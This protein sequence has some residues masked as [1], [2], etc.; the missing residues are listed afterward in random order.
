MYVFGYDKSH[1]MVAHGGWVQQRGAAKAFHTAASAC[2]RIGLDAIN[3]VG[4][5]LACLP[6]DLDTSV[7]VRCLFG[8]NATA[9]AN[10]MDKV[11]ALVSFAAGQH[12]DQSIMPS[13]LYIESDEINSA[14]YVESLVSK[15]RQE[16][17]TS[18]FLFWR[19]GSDINPFISAAS[20]VADHAFV[21]DLDADRIEKD[22]WV[23][24]IER[25]LLRC[26]QAA[27]TITRIV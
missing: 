27:A 12:R 19:K 6:N 23:N 26:C 10:V 9:T 25:P 16:P 1:T 15:L 24:R 2:W 8:G 17:G 20:L 22:K 7:R 14:A 11:A 13:A 5:I 18:I 21:A 3:R 4:R